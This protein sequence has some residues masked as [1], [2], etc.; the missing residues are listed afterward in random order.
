MLNGLDPAQLFAPVANEKV[1][2]LA[3]SGG[4]DSLALMLLHAAWADP[5]KPTA[6]VYTLDHGLRPEARGE[7]EMVVREAERLG[8]RA[9]LIS[10]TGEKPS[11]GRQEAARAARYRLI[12][13]AMGEDG[14]R[15]L[16]TAHHRRD[17]AETVL[18]R[19]A[20]GSGVS[21]LGGMRGFSQV[22][23]VAIFRPLLDVP[24]EALAELVARHGLTPAA[25][26]SNSDPAY[27]RTR[28]RDALPGLAALGLTEQGLARTARRLQRVDDFAERTA[29]QFLSAHFDLDALGVVHCPRVALAQ[30]DP[31]IAVRVLGHG[32]AAASGG[33]SCSLARVE[34]LA[35][36]IA[37]GEQFAATLAGARVEARDDGIVMFRETGRSGLPTLALA[38]GETALWDGRFEITASV[39][40]SVGPA[41]GLT[42]ERFAALTGTPLAAPVAALRA[43]PLVRGA[44]GAILALGTVGLNLSVSVSQPALTAW[45]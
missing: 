33:K 3:V 38:A 29:G 13:E 1:I 14:A 30:A 21:G 41:A 7:A 27:E 5:G 6:I 12:G 10:W 43:A 11:T 36:R 28:W 8:L 32:L 35:G 39:P 2:G 18:M 34:A 42:R 15:V 40:L 16:L 24:P 17:Q 4:A 45:N 37:A 22:E 20:H 25:D 31:E 9:R 26:P 23:G 44:D 19:L